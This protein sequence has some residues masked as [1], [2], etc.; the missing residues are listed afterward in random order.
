MAEVM[1]IVSLC[2]P[3][4]DTDTHRSVISQA[5]SMTHAHWVEANPVMTLSVGSPA[6]AR[7]RIPLSFRVNGG[8]LVEN[9]LVVRTGQW[10][11]R[12][13]IIPLARAQSSG[14]SQGPWHRALGLSSFSIHSVS[15][16][17]STT[18]LALDHDQATT[19]WATVQG[20]SIAAIASAAPKVSRR[21]K[22]AS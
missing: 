5:V 20:A 14:V 21:R 17:V 16:P 13:S 6:S 15:G 11:A 12:L 10:I 2:M 8:G 7:Y 1:K 3:V 9:T 4:L 19:W 22:V 18:L